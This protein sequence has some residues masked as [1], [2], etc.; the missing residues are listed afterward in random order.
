M[1]IQPEDSVYRAIVENSIDAVVIINR[2]GDIIA[3]NSAAERIFGYKASEVLG[4]YVHDIL[5]A[6]NLRDKANKSFQKFQKKGTGPLVG[7]VLQVCGLKKNGDEIH[8]QLSFNTTV[9]NGELLAFAFMRDISELVVLQDK[10]E[11][12]ATVDHLT[13]LL[14]RRAFM[15]QAEIAFGLSKRHKEPLSLLMIDLDFF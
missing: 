6:H 8:V 3:W 9:V 12:Q 13:N 2:S 10:L 1:S 15:I 4:K 14:N 5:P 11:Y 7:K